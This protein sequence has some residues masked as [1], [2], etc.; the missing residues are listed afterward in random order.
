ME[1]TILGTTKIPRIAVGTWAWGTGFFGTNRIFG[2]RLQETDLRPVFRRAIACGCTLWDTAPLYNNGASETILGTLG[3][4]HSLQF[5]TK[6][7]PLPFQTKGAMARSLQK[8]LARLRTDHAELFWI[9]TPKHM[10][11]WTKELI[12]L[13]QSGKFRYCGV[14]NHNLQEILQAEHLLR[15]AGLQ[16]AA[17]QNHFSLLYRLPEE[18]GILDW[19]HQNGVVCFAYMVLEQ[20][21]L[22]RRY[23]AEHPMPDHTRRGNAYPPVVLKRLRPLLSLMK[24][25]G[26]RYDADAAQIAIAWAV[27]K[28]TVPIVGMTKPHH[29]TR[30]A[31]AVSIPLTPTEI[32]LLEREAARTGV[33]IPGDW[34]TA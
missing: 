16:L 12:P 17:V 25:I 20:G 7:L 19:C 33:R 23:T 2:C 24:R 32:A 21:A 18:D 22:T 34:E 31:A 10:E 5:S 13:M 8:S 28:G 9:D 15:Q 3:A 26:N 11:K 4:S 29:V 30:D 6:F 1:Y 14:A 27:A